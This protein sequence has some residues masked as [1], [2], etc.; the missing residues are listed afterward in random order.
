M[1]QALTIATEEKTFRH[2]LDQVSTA[3]TNKIKQLFGFIADPNKHTLTQRLLHPCQYP[4]LVL[5][6]PTFPSSIPRL[7][8]T[9]TTS[10]KLM[11]FTGPWTQIY[12]DTP[13]YKYMEQTERNFHAQI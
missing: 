10:K 9:K 2:R 8:T 6:F 4:N 12:P 11:F 7:H 3:I 1:E 5:F 13:P